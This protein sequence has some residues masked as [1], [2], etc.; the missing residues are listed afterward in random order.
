MPMV[1]S[2]LGFVDF[3]S[4]LPLNQVAVLLSAQLFGGI[5]F[6][7]KDVECEDEIGTLSL[8]NDFLGIQVDLLGEAG[9]FTLEL[10][11]RPSASVSEVEEVCDLSAMLK[12]GIERVE[13]LTFD[14][15]RF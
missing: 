2:V 14:P 15:P 11:T 5:R 7:E 8:E 13:A 4:A 12:Q 3:T 9:L 6:I 1:G 10:A